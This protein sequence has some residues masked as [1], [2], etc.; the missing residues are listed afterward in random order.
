MLTIKEQANRQTDVSKTESTLILSGSSTGYSRE[1]A[2]KY[3]TQIQVLTHPQHR[4]QWK[5][6]FG[7]FSV[8]GPPG[9]SYFWRNFLSYGVQTIKYLPRGSLLQN[10]FSRWTSVPH[11]S[12]RSS[13]SSL[14]PPWS[15]QTTYSLN[16]SC[17]PS[18]RPSSLFTQ[19][20]QPLIQGP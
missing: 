8:V 17:V 13:L 19:L 20:E 1:L 18:S 2:N 9:P 15:L 16:H 5:L 14:I 7:A 10:N 12:Y 6:D 3:V 11:S 4:T